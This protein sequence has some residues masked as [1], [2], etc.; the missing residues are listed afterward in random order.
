MSSNLAISILGFI[1]SFIAL[2]LKIFYFPH[3]P[4]LPFVPFLSILCLKISFEKALVG[5][6]LCGLLMD[7]L[8]ND[9]FGVHATC[10]F[11]VCLLTIRIKYRFQSDHPL[12]L[13][14]FSFIPSFAYT[15]LHLLMLFLFDRKI[16]FMG[17]WFWVQWVLFPFFD[18]LYT[19]IWFVCPLL[20]FAKLWKI[21]E[22][23]K[24]RKWAAS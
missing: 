12:H 8:S 2:T 4:I 7:L 1:L 24:I 15:Q 6:T 13:S 19:F 23:F 10:S 22:N 9:P 20:G 11:I 17:K 5:G 21:W 18:S 16:E 3:L 14:L